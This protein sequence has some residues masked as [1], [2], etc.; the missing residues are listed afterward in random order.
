MELLT[1]TNFKQMPWSNGGGITT[2]LYALE[3]PFVFRL[4]VASVDTSGAFSIYPM[5]DRTLLLLAGDGFVLN[6]SGEIIQLNSKFS[7]IYFFG[8][9]AINCSLLN[10]PCK[11]FN[12]MINRQWGRCTTHIV[13]R[14]TKISIAANN[15]VT[16]IFDYELFKL[17]KIEADE[18]IDFEI[19]VTVPLIIVVI[20][21]V[22]AH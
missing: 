15:L 11:D 17:W 3:N 7:P 6:K 2:E 9:D 21:E 13:K 20:N 16:F 8:E 14:H 12:I 18:Q 5:I 10:D 1:Q 4:S 19:N 22:Y